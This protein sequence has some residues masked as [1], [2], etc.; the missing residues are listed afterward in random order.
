MSRR[1]HTNTPVASH[2]HTSSG[3]HLGAPAAHTS[4]EGQEWGRAGC[5]GSCSQTGWCGQGSGLSGEGM[6]TDGCMCCSFSPLGSELALGAAEVQLESPRPNSLQC[7]CPDVGLTQKCSPVFPSRRSLACSNPA[8]TLTATQSWLG[9]CFHYVPVSCSLP[10]SCSHP[11]RPPG[12]RLRDPLPAAG[13][14]L[15]GTVLSMEQPGEWLVV[16]HGAG[17]TMGV[18]RVRR[19]QVRGAPFTFRKGTT[20]GRSG[21][22]VASWSLAWNSSMVSVAFCRR[23][24][25]L[26]STCPPR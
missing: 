11:I 22:L 3:T 9:S 12:A 2:T 8:L 10:P 6:G 20:K 23:Q 7:T 5:P 15:A 19:S 1:Y 4:S 16:K 14:G 17:G 21:K 24:P 18:L 13:S 26:V 25:A